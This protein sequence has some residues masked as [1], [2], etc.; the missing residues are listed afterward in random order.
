MAEVLRAQVTAYSPPPPQLAKRILQAESFEPLFLIQQSNAPPARPLVMPARM[1]PLPHFAGL[2]LPQLATP[3]ELALWLGLSPRHLDWFA[4]ISGRNAGDER[5]TLQHYRWHWLPRRGAAPRLI[6]A[7]KAE[8]KAMQQRILREILDPVACHPAAKGFRKGR[9]CLDHA[10][11]HAGERLVIA[12]DLRDFFLRVPLRRVHGLF[13]CLGYP[14]P[15]ARLLTGLCSTRLPQGAFDALTEEDR[16]HWR[17]RSRQLSPH[18][19]QGAPSSPAL[20]NLCSWRLDLRLAGLARRF[21]TNYSRYA[22]DLAFSGDTALAEAVRPFLGSLGKI[23]REE[24]HSL[25]RSKTR[26]MGQSARQRLTG[27]VVNRHL[28]L[29]RKDHDALKATLFNCLRRGPQSQNRSDHPAFRQH[30]EGRVLWAERVNPCRG[31]KLRALFDRIDWS[32]SA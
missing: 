19:P 24:G 9:S 23:V 25:N 5:A 22:D 17:S 18:L 32:E 28:N 20:A 3:G 10:Q 12:A 14:W 6:E 30:L 21:D 15:V 27:L 4:D 7:P 26:V 8:L 13:R 16:P 1:T 11:R 29:S 31:A 2:S